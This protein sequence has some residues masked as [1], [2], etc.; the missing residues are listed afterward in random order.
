MVVISS[1]TDSCQICEQIL[2]E[3]ARNLQKDYAEN[4][5]LKELLLACNSLE[6]TY[7]RETV[8]KC[9]GFTYPNID[10]IYNDFKAGK[11]AHSTCVEIGQ[12]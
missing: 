8:Q 12:C 5:L 2:Q 9:I 3:A 6:A 4:E 7:D 10:I 1:E 11:D